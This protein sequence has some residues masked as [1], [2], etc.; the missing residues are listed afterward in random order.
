MWIYTIYCDKEM[1]LKK[2]CPRC[3]ALID[4][5]KIYCDACQKE[6]DELQKKQDRKYNAEVRFVRDKQYH[7]FYNSPEWQQVRN[8]AIARDHALCQDC[9]KQHIIKPYDVVH[10]IVP[11][12]DNWN[13]RLE[14]DNLVCLCESCHQERHKKMR[15]NVDK[16]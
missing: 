2:T 5:N 7:E 16:K 11:I 15:G 13:K 8:A 3:G 6:V 10:H 14:L 4:F 12:K 1:S 9:L